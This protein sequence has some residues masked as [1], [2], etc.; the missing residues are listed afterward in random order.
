VLLVGA[1]WV[2]V[3]DDARTEVS[4]GD[5]GRDRSPQSSPALA[6]TREQE[7]DELGKGAAEKK[8]M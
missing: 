7:R 2:D 5:L 1:A 8:A 4:A 3:N 6:S